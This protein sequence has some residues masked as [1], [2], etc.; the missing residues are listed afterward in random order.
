MIFVIIL[1][2]ISKAQSNEHNVFDSSG[3][4]YS[5]AILQPEVMS[6]VYRA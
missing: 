4:G 2:P 1:R 5:T 3:T 6:V